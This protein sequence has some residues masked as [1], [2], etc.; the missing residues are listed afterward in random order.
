MINL[1]RKKSNKRN[2]NLWVD[3]DLVAKIKKLELNSSVIFTEAAEKKLKE[4][5]ED[6]K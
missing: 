2:L 1:A 4:M 3:K 5:K 6:E